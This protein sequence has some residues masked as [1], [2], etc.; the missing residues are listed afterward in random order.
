MRSSSFTRM[1]ELQKGK[2][3]EQ[4]CFL[5]SFLLYKI[6]LRL[7]WPHLNHYVEVEQTTLHWFLF[8]SSYLISSLFCFS[9]QKF[10]ALHCCYFTNLNK[11]QVQKGKSVPILSYQVYATDDTTLIDMGSSV[12][13]FNK[14]YNFH[15]E[16]LSKYN[17]RKKNKLK[18]KSQFHFYFQFAAESRG[19]ENEG[20]SVKIHDSHPYLTVHPHLLDAEASVQGSCFPS[21][22]L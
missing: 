9:E 11:I 5:L 2:M 1:Q 16:P 10:L 4:F 13:D 12:L 19:E 18:K 6:R 7:L 15:T 3:E 21:L 22:S 14:H 20:N 17:H 8:P